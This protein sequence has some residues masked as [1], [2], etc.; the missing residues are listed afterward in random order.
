MKDEEKPL[1]FDNDD[2]PLDFEDEEFIDDK[3]E[4]ELYNT[5]TEDGS[6]VDPADDAKHRSRPENSDPI[7]VD[8]KE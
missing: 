6:S 3:R 5:I 7:E 2:E 8:E 4:D 1:D